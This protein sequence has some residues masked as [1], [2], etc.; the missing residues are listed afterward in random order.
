MKGNRIVELREGININTQ[1]PVISYIYIIVAYV[2]KLYLQPLWVDL[3][4]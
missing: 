3:K 1:E 4:N 2:S